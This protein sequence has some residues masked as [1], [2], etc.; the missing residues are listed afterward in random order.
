MGL[1][2]SSGQG[3]SF[4]LRHIAGTVMPYYFHER[5]GKWQIPYLVVEMAYDGRSVNTLA[6]AIVMELD[7]ILP[8]ANYYSLVMG[9]R[10]RNAETR[11]VMALQLAYLH[12]VGMI[13]VDETQNQSSVDGEDAPTQ[14]RRAP[15]D[16]VR[17]N[18]LAK[19]L[20]TASNVSHMPLLMAGTPEMFNTV[21][22]RFTRSRRLAGN[23][24]AS[25]P[26]DAQ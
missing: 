18:P 6:T 1:I 11:L 22:N 23:G 2:G 8:D 17:E 16:A 10:G 13:V 4:T 25:G 7:R 20:I 5:T 26:P 15:K 21:G 12:G 24:S 9:G 3:K 19:L 14:K